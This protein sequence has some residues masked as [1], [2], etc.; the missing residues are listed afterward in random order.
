MY[1]GTLKL[2]HVASKGR[3]VD[4]PTVCGEEFFVEPSRGHFVCRER[5]EDNG[6]C[7]ATYNMGRG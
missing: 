7:C 2:F 5:N 3:F 4:G 6:Y 1:W